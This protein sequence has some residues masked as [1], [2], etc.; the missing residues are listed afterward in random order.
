MHTRVRKRVSSFKSALVF[1]TLLKFLNLLFEACKI[2]AAKQL[3]V[4]LQRTLLNGQHESGF[5]LSIDVRLLL[6]GGLFTSQ[7][8][9]PSRGIQ[10]ALTCRVFCR[11]HQ[12]CIMLL[13]RCLFVSQP[14]CAPSCCFES[15]SRL[16][17]FLSFIFIVQ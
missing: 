3:F 1:L 6:K 11:S 8:S 14:Y 13:E 2:D 7:Q 17:R 9:L 10:R 15:V 16:N 4:M 12:I 5:A